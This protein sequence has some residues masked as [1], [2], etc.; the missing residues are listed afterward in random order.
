[1]TF[2]DWKN[3]GCVR[4]YCEALVGLDVT[5][6]KDWADFKELVYR[7]DRSDIVLKARRLASASTRHDF[8]ALAAVLMAMDY[9]STAVELDA[10][11][12]SVLGHWQ[13]TTGERLDALIGVLSMSKEPAI[14]A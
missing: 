3:L 10:K 12:G 14:A 1:M 13:F 6:M 8:V 9:S 2:D 5:A 4:L 11:H 7:A